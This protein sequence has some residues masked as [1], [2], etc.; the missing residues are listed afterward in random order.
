MSAAKA[1]NRIILKLH[2]GIAWR[3]RQESHEIQS[4]EM[5]S[6]STDLDFYLRMVWVC[7]RTM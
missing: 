3:V 6:H 4:K 1:Y 7:R 2:G 5:Q